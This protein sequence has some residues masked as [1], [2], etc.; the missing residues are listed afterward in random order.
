MNERSSYA[1]LAF[2]LLTMLTGFPSKDRAKIVVRELQDEQFKYQIE[3][4]GHSVVSGGPCNYPQKPTRI[5]TSDWIY[6]DSNFGK[7]DAKEF[8]FSVYSPDD[9]PQSKP[10]EHQVIDIRGWLEI[11]G[12]EITIDIE[13]PRTVS[14][15]TFKYV[16]YKYNGVYKFSVK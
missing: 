9:F 5:K 11:T 8:V 15:S 13:I 3:I 16:S 14:D 1:F 4:K 10:W 6:L 2:A 12:N 7:K